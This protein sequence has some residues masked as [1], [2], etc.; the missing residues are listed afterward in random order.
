MLVGQF[1]IIN[2][3]DLILTPFYHHT[4]QT[5]CSSSVFLGN[6]A[7][8]LLGGPFLHNSAWWA[9]T[10]PLKPSSIPPLWIVLFCWFSHTFL[11][12]LLWN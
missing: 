1:L 9:P 5:C 4:L 6:P 7:A 10:H 2:A 8:P 3:P 12:P 11:T